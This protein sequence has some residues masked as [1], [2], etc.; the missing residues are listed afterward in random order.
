MLA[1]VLKGQH[2]FIGQHAY[3]A[4]FALQVDDLGLDDAGV[5]RG[6]AD[7]SQ[8]VHVHAQVQIVDDG[9]QAQVAQDLLL[10]LQNQYVGGR[11]AFVHD[12]FAVFNDE[13]F[14]FGSHVASP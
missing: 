3:L 2:R 9:V 1:T 13:N 8:S 7:I 5:G 12:V 4:E 6:G 14:I 11:R 10:L